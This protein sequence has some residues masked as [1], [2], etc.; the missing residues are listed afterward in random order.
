MDGS[1]ITLI[2]LGVMVL[3]FLGANEITTLKRRV[4]ELERKEASKNKA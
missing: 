4:D 3:W 2:A 1:L